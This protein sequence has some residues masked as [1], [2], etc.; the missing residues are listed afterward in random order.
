MATPPMLRS[1]GPVVPTAHSAPDPVAG[2]AV[3]LMALVA[4]GL[5]L[6]AVLAVYD[7]ATPPALGPVVKAVAAL[8]AAAVLI[9]VV[10]AAVRH[11]RRIGR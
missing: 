7:V 1:R 4:L 11:A 3:V 10:G 5:L 2:L 9:I 8:F 6:A